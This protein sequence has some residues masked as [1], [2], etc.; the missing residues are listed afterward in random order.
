MRKECPGEQLRVCTQTSRPALSSDR[1]RRYR[2]VSASP[3]QVDACPSRF[4][5]TCFTC[6]SNV[7]VQAAITKYH[8]PE[9]LKQHIY[10][11]PI[12]RLDVQDQGAGRF[13]VSWVLSQELGW[14]CSQRGW[15]G[16]GGPLPSQG[17]GNWVLMV[18][19]DRN[20]STRGASTERASPQAAWVS[21]GKGG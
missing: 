8:S 19:R 21:W 15:T 9:G 14:G 6:L 12:R 11:S 3:L 16:D 4:F 17:S 7:L 10:F 20:S 5:S 13:G 1:R 18:A 2:S